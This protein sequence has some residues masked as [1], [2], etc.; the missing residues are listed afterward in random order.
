MD[1][2]FSPRREKPRIAQGAAQRNP[3]KPCPKA[4]LV[5]E[6][7][8]ELS[9]HVSN[10]GPPLQSPTVCVNA[11]VALLICAVRSSLSQLNGFPSIARFSV[12]NS[13]IENTCR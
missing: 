5:P 6:G 7:R 12:L 11:S 10:P 1:P 4:D 2:F 9:L 13:T 8:G 3:G